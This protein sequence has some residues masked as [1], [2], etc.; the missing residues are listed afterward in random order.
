MPTVES[1]L[2]IVSKVFKKGLEGLEIRRRID[3]IQTTAL[4]ISAKIPR[5]VLET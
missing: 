5:R 2:G 1:V 4:L 3:T